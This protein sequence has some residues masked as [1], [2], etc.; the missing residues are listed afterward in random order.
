MSGLFVSR[1]G[2]T[3]IEQIAG[4]G[5]GQVELSSGFN[6]SPGT[7]QDITL[8]ED[9]STYRWLLVASGPDADTFDETQR[10][11]TRVIRE[12][13]TGGTFAGAVVSGSIQLY[14]VNE[15]AQTISARGSRLGSGFA[16]GMGMT[17]SGN[18]LYTAN[19]ISNTTIQINRV[20]NLT[21][22]TPIV[23]ISGFGSSA[24]LGTA[25]IPDG[26]GNL[27]L[28]G[29]AGRGASVRVVNVN[30]STGTFTQLANITHVP[31]H[32]LGA[33]RVGS[34][35]YLMVIGTPASLRTYTFYRYNSNNT[36]TALGTGTP[37]TDTTLT[38]G[39]YTTSAG[40]VKALFGTGQGSDI[41]L[42]TMNTSD[43]SYTQDFKVTVAGTRALGLSGAS[44]PALPPYTVVSDYVGLQ[45]VGQRTLRFYPNKTGR[46]HYVAGV[47]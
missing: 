23:S 40:V 38:G 43:G 8:S 27:I 3:A 46:V 39:M 25:L 1:K 13:T 22:L 9:L 26:S 4:G 44:S 18:S 20:N 21:S 29:E 47:V 12:V 2:S 36:L 33:A 30:V 45:R 15:A 19:Q 42:A 41:I 6:L 10:I 11:P 34:A 17:F 31:F 14:D 24:T 37:I 16:R 5:G 35:I 7:S 32:G 28:F